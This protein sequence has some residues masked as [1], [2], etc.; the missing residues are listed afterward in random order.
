MNNYRC[1]QCG[2][3]NWATTD[4]CKRCRLPNPATGQTQFSPSPAMPNTMIAATSPTVAQM[5]FAP[6][7]NYQNPQNYQ[8][9]PPPFQ[10]QRAGSY[11]AHNT[12]QYVNNYEP[13]NNYQT[14]SDEIKKAEKYAKSGW[15]GGVVWASLLGFATVVFMM[16]PAAMKSSLPN[17]PTQDFALVSKVMVFILGGMTILIGGLSYGVK[18]KSMAC[19]VILAVIALLGVINSVSEKLPGAVIFGL[20]MFS[21]FAMAASGINTLKK[22]HQI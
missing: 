11:A 17:D 7:P 5:P 15:I 13:Q 22:H 14:N 8:T 19:A 12:S 9:A 10:S 16:L 20:L 18:R 2:L 21:L 6:S 3:L 1:P 4:Q